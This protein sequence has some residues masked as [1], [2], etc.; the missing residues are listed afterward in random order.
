MQNKNEA[1]SQK[2]DLFQE[3]RIKE[4]IDALERI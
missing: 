1:A 4:L 3:Y 2:D